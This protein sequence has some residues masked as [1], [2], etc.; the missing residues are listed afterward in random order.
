MKKFIISDWVRAVHAVLRKYVY[1]ETN[2]VQK[3]EI[4]S[5]IFV[6]LKI[7]QKSFLGRKKPL[8]ACIG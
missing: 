3:K 4:D 1:S 6:F 7:A 8:S 5:A 2:T